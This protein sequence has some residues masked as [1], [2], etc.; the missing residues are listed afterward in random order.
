MNEY[1][2]LVLLEAFED[3]LEKIAGLPR[4]VRMGGGGYAGQVMREVAEKGKE[5][6]KHKARGPQYGLYSFSKT[7]EYGKNRPK[8]RKAHKQWSEATKAQGRERKAYL[9]DVIK[10]RQYHPN[11]GAAK[12]GSFQ[13]LP[14]PKPPRVS[15]PTVGKAKQLMRRLGRF[16][17]K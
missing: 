6:A 1:E 15:S 12:P 11:V 8:I 16:F 17:S 9:A 13:K 10:N 2:E 14:G 5:V 4:A 3:E 7:Y